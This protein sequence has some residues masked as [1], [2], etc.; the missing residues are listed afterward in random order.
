MLKDIKGFIG[1]YAISLNGEVWAYPKQHGTKFCK[2]KFLKPFNKGRYSM[3]IL[4]KNKLNKS[5]SI[6]RLVAET[7]IP[8]PKELPQVNHKN[9]NRLDNR[10][11]NLEWCTAKQNIKHADETG[12]RK[13]LNR[14]KLTGKYLKTI[15]VGIT[16]DI[17][18]KLYETNRQ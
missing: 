2:G 14:C 8:N 4:A 5:K 18:K 9:G 17:T 11:E 15:G 3:V 13:K 7:Y 6:H 1:L 12:L 16:E 10:I